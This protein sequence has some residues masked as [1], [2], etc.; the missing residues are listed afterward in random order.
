MHMDPANPTGC[1][2]CALLISKFTEPGRRDEHFEVRYQI[3]PRFGYFIRVYNVVFMRP[4]SNTLVR[5]GLQMA[6]LQSAF[7]GLL[8]V[9]I[10]IRSTD[11]PKLN[12]GI[13]RQWSSSEL[14][15]R[16]VR[17]RNVQCIRYASGMMV[18]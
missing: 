16:H 14:N 8:R 13:I 17:T 4:D 6:R 2:V 9:T 1:R 15:W 18:A 3:E 11:T 7:L 12:T 5:L 10:D